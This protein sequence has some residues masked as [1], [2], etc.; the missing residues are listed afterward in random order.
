MSTTTEHLAA[1]Q[2]RPCLGLASV[3]KRIGI[4]LDEIAQSTRIAPRYLQAIDAEEFAKLPSGV[5]A[6]SYIRQYARAIG[7]NETELIDHYRALRQ[8]E[9]TPIDAGPQRPRVTSRLGEA[10][11]DAMDLLHWRSP[12]KSRTHHPA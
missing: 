1:E 4:T 7:Y 9:P 6:I 3:R 2:S 12:A 5:Y 10:L 8:P 11:G